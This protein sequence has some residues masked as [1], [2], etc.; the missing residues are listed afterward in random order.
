MRI[1]ADAR[2]AEAD[3]AR[4]ALRRR[5]EIGEAP[6]PAVGPHEDAADIVDQVG[7]RRDLLDRIA[8]PPL[9]RDGDQVGQGHHADGVAI[10]RGAGDRGEADLTARPGAIDDDEG[11]AEPRL[12]PATEA[13]RGDIGA[14][15]RSEGH[16]HGDRLLRP[17]RARRRRDQ[18]SHQ[19]R[20]QPAHRR[21]P[22]SLGRD[23]QPP[24]RALRP[25]AS[26]IG[27]T[28]PPGRP[29]A[30]SSCRQCCSV[31]GAAP[32][33]RASAWPTRRPPAEG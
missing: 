2:G 9:E 29:L 15:A 13:A 18:A 5:D 33:A 25:A 8:R 16:H 11:L 30:A 28:G 27:S 20:K 22:L 19:Q 7:D 3:R 31:R 17:G 23:Y 4:I 21:L 10:R 1:G 6:E 12:D 14:A 32:L 24:P 26:A